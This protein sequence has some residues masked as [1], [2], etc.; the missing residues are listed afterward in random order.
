MLATAMQ[1]QPGVYALLLGSGISTGA[2]IPTGW[3][4]VTSLVEKAAV[5]MG[6]LKDVNPLCAMAI[7]PIP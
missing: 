3:G 7:R 5:F 4:V 6:S 1:S 2:G